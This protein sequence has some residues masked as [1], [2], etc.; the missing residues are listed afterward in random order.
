MSMLQ[1]AGPED[2][3]Q[4]EL[5]AGR[6]FVNEVVTLDNRHFRECVF[7]QCTLEYSGRPVVL[8]LT[9]FNGCR[10]QFHDA[11]ALTVKLLECFE[12]MSQTHADYALTTEGMALPP[13]LVN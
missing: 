6:K 2:S 4:L 13:Q 12:M 10:F 7:E 3:P 8:E 11:A 9:R 1:Q 5:V